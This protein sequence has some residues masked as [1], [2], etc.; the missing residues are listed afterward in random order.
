[1]NEQSAIGLSS[2]A[3]ALT[4]AGLRAELGLTLAEMGER[5]GLSKSQ[6]HD[7]EKSDRAS[8]R[9]ALEIERLSGGRIDAA[10]LNEDVRASR[11]AVGLS[12][13]ALDAT[14]RQRDHG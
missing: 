5:V 11:N 10:D 8:L 2:P 6:M 1:M 12:H 9:V 14:E 7:V 13:A 3:P 4:V